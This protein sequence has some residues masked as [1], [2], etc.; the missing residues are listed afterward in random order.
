[1]A[2]GRTGG[3]VVVFRALLPRGGRNCGVRNWDP[4][5]RDPQLRDPRCQQG[6]RQRGRF[7]PRDPSVGAKVAARRAAGRVGKVGAA[8]WRCDGFADVAVSSRMRAFRKLVVWRKAHALALNI[9]RAVNAKRG[10]VDA[11]LRNQMG[12]AAF[13]IP[14]N[15]E[16]GCCQPGSGRCEP[17]GPRP[18]ITASCSALGCPRRSSGTVRARPGR[19]CHPP[20]AAFR[21][22]PSR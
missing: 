21:A 1:M 18:A 10:G 3:R 11:A 15:I 8:L 4:Q 19:S 12:R 2:R 16:R 17:A 5:L 7:T 13:S 20:Q 9:H 14:A 6:R 22:D